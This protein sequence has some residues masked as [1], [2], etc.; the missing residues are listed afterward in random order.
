[1]ALSLQM[2]TDQLRALEL[3][4]TA[5]IDEL[6]KKNE[7]AS[8]TLQQSLE[9]TC[10]EL[11]AKNAILE[12]E[13]REKASLQKDLNE[14]VDTIQTSSETAKEELASKEQ[15]KAKLLKRISQLEENHNNELRIWDEKLKEKVSNQEMELAAL[16]L[17]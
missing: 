5:K 13:K 8:T 10:K 17:E 9:S 6:N 3:E 4:T 2:K 14:A 11:N 12:E 7:E 15:D 16:R 1:M